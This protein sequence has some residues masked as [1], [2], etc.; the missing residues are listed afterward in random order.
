MLTRPAPKVGKGARDDPGRRVRHQVRNAESGG[1]SGRPGALAAVLP[2]LRAS[3]TGQ[4]RP[5]C[6]RLVKL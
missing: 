2:P 4:D 6:A 1:T 3:S 5:Q